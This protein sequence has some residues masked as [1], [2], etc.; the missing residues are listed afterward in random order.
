MRL[1]TGLYAMA[2]MGMNT[3]LYSTSV[4]LD[5][6]YNVSIAFYDML[7]DMTGMPTISDGEL[8]DSVE[9]WLLT[10][11]A[12]D[13]FKDTVSDKDLKNVLATGRALQLQVMFAQTESA[14]VENGDVDFD[15]IQ[16]A[17]R[18]APGSDNRVRGD[19]RFIN[20]GCYCT[21]SESHFNSEHWY[22]TGEPV[23]E[24]D[25]VCRNLFFGYQCLKNDHGQMCDSARSYEWKVGDNGQPTCGKFYCRDS[26]GLYLIFFIFS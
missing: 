9:E 17:A 18:G 20:Y 21:P 5:D 12:A 10:A 19:E 16:I 8:R 14:A 6:L 22:G 7:N 1:I 25:S 2:A 15:Y 24:I 23:D 13:E 26:L 4:M 11:E 3:E